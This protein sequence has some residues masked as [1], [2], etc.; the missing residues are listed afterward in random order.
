M[1]SYAGALVE[2]GDIIKS[3]CDIKAELGEVIAGIKRGRKSPETISIYKSLGLAVQDL[4]AAKLISD[5]SQS[6]D[7]PFPIKRVK[8]SDV[9]EKSFSNE[10]PTN[11]VNCTEAICQAES[12]T[13]MSKVKFYLHLNSITCELVITRNDGGA[14]CTALCFMYDAK[15]GQLIAVI[16]DWKPNAD[17]QDRIGI[18][19]NITGNHE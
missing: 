12:V 7:N 3:K 6:T 2:S 1:D 19:S 18:I 4:T 5:I 10:E 8:M 13:F 9:E 11:N 16:E 14:V 17:E 15:T